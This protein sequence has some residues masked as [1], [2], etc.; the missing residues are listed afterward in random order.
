M[1]LRT[2]AEHL[3]RCMF[4][5]FPPDARWDPER[6]VVEFGIGVGEY[7]GVA[8]LPNLTFRGPHA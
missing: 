6:G 8:R 5:R 7:K 4:F 2:L 1:F 3:R